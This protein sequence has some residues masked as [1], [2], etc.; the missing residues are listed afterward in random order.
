[1]HDRTVGIEPWLMVDGIPVRGWGV[2]DRRYDR[3][4]TLVRGGTAFDRT[5]IV[6]VGRSWSGTDFHEGEHLSRRYGY[7]PRRDLADQEC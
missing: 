4:E 5:S 6:G 7:P 1:M 3:T 2:W